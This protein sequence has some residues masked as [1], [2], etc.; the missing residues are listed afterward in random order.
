M[1]SKIGM[2]L[3]RHIYEGERVHPEATGELTGILNQIALAAKI[4]S[5]EV[6]KA[7]LAEIL[8]FTGQ[9]NVQGEEVRKLDQFANDVFMTAFSHLGHFC[10]MASEEV[11]KPIPMPVDG[12]PDGGRYSVVFDPLDGSSNIDANVGVGSIFAVH[13]KISP[14]RDGTITDLL[15]PGRRLAAAGYVVYGSSTMLV[16]STGHGVHAFTLDP[17]VGEFLQS[18]HHIR[19]RE[20]GTIYSANEGN[21]PYWSQGVRRFVSHMKQHDPTTGRP[22]SSRYIGSMV[23]DIHR[24]LLYGGIFMYPAD[25]KDPKKPHG[26]L[27]LLYECSPIAFLLEQ[28]GGAA[29]DGHRPI[30]DIQPTEVHQRTPFFAGSVENVREVETFIARY[31]AVRA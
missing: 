5:R 22:Y 8:G 29:S 9:R 17:S 2:T 28:A 23:A 14:G 16:L 12:R 1:D 4:V 27:R 19:I 18:H 3:T 11:D 20:R 26:K 25:S 6:R 15:Q 7:G 31:D 13:H 21:Y 10:I 24:T 30:L